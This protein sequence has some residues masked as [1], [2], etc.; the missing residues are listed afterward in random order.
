M[1]LCN[2]KT[3]EAAIIFMYGNVS[4]MITNVTTFVICVSRLLPTCQAYAAFGIPVC[5]QPCLLLR[6]LRQKWVRNLFTVR[7]ATA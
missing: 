6:D 7:K 2:V 4:E 1:V 3:S 5:N